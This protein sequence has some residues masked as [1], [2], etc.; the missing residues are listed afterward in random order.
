MPKAKFE[1]Q[2]FQTAIKS[3]IADVIS[4][5]ALGGLFRRNSWTF[6]ITKTSGEEL[7]IKILKNTDGAESN[8]NN[9]KRSLKAIEHI[10]DI[11]VSRLIDSGEIKVK[12]TKMPYLVFP[13][14]SGESLSKLSTGDCK[15]TEDETKAFT[16]SL[17]NTI[18]QLAKAGIIHQ[19]IKPDNIVKMK[20]GSF[21]LLDLGIARFIKLDPSFVKQQG[22]AA[23]LSM[24][25][26]ELG[27]K[28][29]PVNKRRVT[30]LSDLNSLGIVAVNLLLGSNAFHAQWALDRR[31][32]AAE[33]IRS[34]EIIDI[35]DDE[36]RNLVASLL[37]ASPSTRLFRLKDLI[38]ISPFIPKSSN[39]NKYW[40]LHKP[41]GLSFIKKFAKD[42]NDISMGLV[43]SA[44]TVQSVSSTDII[45]KPLVENGWEL[46]VDPSTHKLLYNRD[47]HA[48]LKIRDYYREDLSIDDFFDASFTKTF[49]SQVMEFERSL[50]PTLYI[51][52]YF[53]LTNSYDQKLT[54]GISLYK[55]AQGYLNILN[56]SKPLALGLCVSKP[57]ICN[58]KESDR[59]ADQIVLDNS[60]DIV[61]LNIELV[62]SD[63]RPAKDADYLKG[64][65]RL[66]ERLATTKKVIVSQVDQFGLGLLTIDKVSLAV[67]PDVS[68]RKN[69]IDEK[70]KEIKPE[71]GWGPKAEDRRNR[72]YIPSMLT[73]LDIDR[74]INQ[75][76]GKVD[77][78]KG[79]KSPYYNDALDIGN[80]EARNLHF[81]YEFNAQCQKLGGAVC[82]KD[83]LKSMIAEAKGFFKSI[84]SSGIKLDTSTNQS[85]DFL[86]AWEDAF[87]NSK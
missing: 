28:N 79:M 48:H 76:H 52:P 85:A 4:V 20:D 38:D 39:L 19:D 54:V 46:A 32:E 56:D 80:K 75:L 33:R 35:Q 57:L 25:Q 17:I 65:R 37:E 66:V 3:E 68:Y 9:E 74:D 11:N 55:E 2:D 63:N 5:S 51:S 22:P 87:V 58:E 67:N 27:V 86:V 24:E 59:L 83:E 7:V 78:K 10:P 16:K 41:T 81:T 53:Y 49:T 6:K 77:L 45:T 8:I 43:L 23:Y 69:D 50:N 40:S 64:V 60:I 1:G 13:Y 72:V 26:I 21:V 18:L 42:N 44:E 15:F 29:N 71:K 82:P 30:F 61:Y 73:D 31:E 36:L 14:Y 34:K 47:H 84:E 12:S 70:L 62:K